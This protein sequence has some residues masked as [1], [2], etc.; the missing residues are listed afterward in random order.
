MLVSACLEAGGKGFDLAG[1]RLGRK[2][3]RELG[4]DPGE[5]LVELGIAD[6]PRLQLADRS[7]CELLLLSDRACSSRAAVDP[8]SS[9]STAS[10]CSN[11]TSDSCSA[12][13]SS[14]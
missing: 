7:R 8:A 11:A 9:A 1:V 13:T 5:P 4:L 10:R 2:S 12:T 14:G 6:G 3:L